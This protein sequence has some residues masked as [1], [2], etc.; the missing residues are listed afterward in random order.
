MNITLLEKGVTLATISVDIMAGANRQA[1]YLSVNPAG[2]LPANIRLTA[3][4]ERMS[5]RPSVASQG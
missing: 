5:K 2:Q 3:W 1:P 4:F